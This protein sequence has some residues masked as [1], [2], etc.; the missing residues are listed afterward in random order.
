MILMILPVSGK[1]FIAQLG[2]IQILCEGNIKPDIMLASSGGNI[3]SYVAAAANWE[4]SAIERIA[5][6]IKSKFLLQPWSNIS[7][8]SSIIGY[9]KGNI[10]N[11]GEG[12]ENFL[13]EFFDEKTITKYET[14]TGTFNIKSKKSKLFCNKKKEDCLLDVSFIDYDLTQSEPPHFAN[15]DFSIIAKSCIASASI[16][17]IVPPEKINNNYYMDGG[18]S[19]ASPL[20][21]LHEPIL[22][23]TCKNKSKLHMIYINCCDLSEVKNKKPSNIVDTLMEA[24]IDM[25][26]CQNV[27]DRLTTYELLRCFKGEMNKEEFEFNQETIK[28]I[29][30]IYDSNSYSML[31]IYPT[32]DVDVDIANFSQEDI[33]KNINIAYSNCRC[34]FW[35]LSN[36]KKNCKTDICRNYM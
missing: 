14:W 28:Y 10:Y 13:K 34:R 5:G 12:L 7:I 17:G 18:V 24:S 32:K 31:E 8:V 22:K 3:A 21:I 16:P 35:W 33:V 9:F 1:K 29:K 27:I 36:V 4:C 19:C 2:E 15:G 26:R 20:T 23:Y 25:L 6:Q 11:N 30:K